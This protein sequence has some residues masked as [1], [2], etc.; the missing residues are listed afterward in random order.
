M[1]AEGAGRRR[2]CAAA[3]AAARP[4]F[5][6]RAP[7]A[8]MDAAERI[9]EGCDELHR[10][11]VLLA[12]ASGGEPIRGKT[13]LQKM[14]FMLTLGEDGSKSPHG[15]DADNY[16]PH[17]DIVDEEARYLEDVGVLC[18][19]GAN[20]SVTALGRKVAGR[21]AEREEKR[22][23]DMIDE[24]KEVFNDMTA[25]EL[26]AYVYSAYPDMAARSPAYDRVMSNVESHVMSLLKK[27]KVALGRAA[28]LLGRPYEDVLRMAGKMR[29]QTLK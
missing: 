28:E 20:I 22:A 15:Y 26:L 18:V 8:G 10:L 21:V 14:V 13:K 19:D 27:E 7:R 6:R 11:I 24:Y 5:I 29:I 12:D 2:A 3:R 4:V 25:D 17:S 9:A 1:R 16:G 23:L